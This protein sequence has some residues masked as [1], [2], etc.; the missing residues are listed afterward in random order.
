MSGGSGALKHR[1]DLLQSLLCESKENAEVMADIGS[2]T[3]DLSALFK[4]GAFFAVLRRRLDSGL[5]SY[6]SLILF[7]RHH[8]GCR[9]G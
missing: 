1:L 2:S 4:S 5:P 9:P 8:G 3:L 7:R 6:L